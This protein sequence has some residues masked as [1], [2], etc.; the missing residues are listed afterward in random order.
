MKLVI[1]EGAEQVERINLPGEV[2]DYD[3]IIHSDD[4]TQFPKKKTKA[5]PPEVPKIHLEN[6]EKQNNR[7]GY[8]RMRDNP[9]SQPAEIRQAVFQREYLTRKQ[10]DEWAKENGYSPRSGGVQTA[11]IVLETVTEEIQRVGSD[12]DQRIIWIGER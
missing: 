3:I 10:L 4:R 12:D 7:E 5:E 2:G 9:E 8:R 11:L 1:Y 6:I